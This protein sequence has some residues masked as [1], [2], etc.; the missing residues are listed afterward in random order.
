LI[1]VD[2]EWK[3]A[4]LDVIEEPGALEFSLGKG[5]WPF[6]GFVLRWQGKVFAYENVCPHAGHP[7][8]MTP[9][10]FFNLDRSLLICSSHGAVFEPQTGE[11]VVGPCAGA[12]LKVLECRVSAEE[13]IYVRAPEA[14][15]A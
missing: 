6:R 1:V 3:V 2:Q 9:Q 15:R 5:D 14:R 7:L 12:A 4:S 13:E 10:G 11:C 8:N